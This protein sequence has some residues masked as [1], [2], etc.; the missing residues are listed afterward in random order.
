RKDAFSI[1]CQFTAGEVPTP[2]ATVGQKIRLTVSEPTDAART[3]WPV[4]SGVPFAQGKLASVDDVQMT[5]AQGKVI[6]AQFDVTSRWH[7]G[8]IKWLTCDFA[9]NTQPGDQKAV[10]FLVT[11]KLSKKEADKGAR[12]KLES[13][14]N[15]ILKQS[16][17]TIV[18]ADGVTLQSQMSDPQVETGG[19]VRVSVKA[20]GDYLKTDKTPLFR[21]RCHVTA[22]DSGFVRV[23][24]TI[25]NNKVDEVTTLVHRADWSLTSK[26]SFDKPTLAD[27]TR[28]QKA[29]SVVQDLEKHA[30][31][32]IDG[33]TSTREQLDG[34]FVCG[35]TAIKACD[36]WQTWPK[37]FAFRKGQFRFD[38][39]P[40]L[41]TTDYPPKGWDTPTELFEHFYWYKDGNYMFK[42]GLEI[43][44]E[45]WLVT[46]KKLVQEGKKLDAWLEHPL[47][48]VAPCDYYCESKAFGNINPKRAG[49][50]DT[51]EKAY[52]DSFANLE[53]GR[54][55][56]G[57][58]GWMNFGDWFGE[59][60]WNWGNNEYD[61]SYLMA[62]QF[63][64]SGNTAYVKRGLEMAKHYTTVDFC[65]Y[66]WQEHARE[67]VYAHSTGH[68]GGFIEEGDPRIAGLQHFIA[69][70]RGGQDGSGGHAFHPGNYFMGCL[71]GEK[72]ILEVAQ[73]ACWNQATWYTPA[74]R[75]SIERAAGWALS[76]AVYSYNFTNNPFYLNAAKIYY[77]VI[78]A[79]QNP[80]T[81]CF[82]LRQDQS[83]CDCPDKKEHRGGKA[84][85]V[86]VLLHALARYYETTNDPKV[87]ETI[88]RCADWLLDYSWNES[89]SGFRYKTGCPK[90]ANSGGY[91]IIV[92]EGIAYATEVS[93]NPRYIE[94]LDRTAGPYIVKPVGG[95]TGAGKT[96]S[97]YQ[98]HLPHLLYYLEKHGKT[99]GVK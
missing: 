31:V 80:V 57:E 51:Y 54:Q 13:R 12:A 8:S 21:W 38:I 40:A 86:G 71:T 99:A 96:F 24:W 94:F 84:F 92:S 76:N 55:K 43:C 75:I 30:S 7:D 72:R 56:R 29:L 22:Y 85:A 11:G 10:Y 15:E 62:E 81:G 50:F 35:D 49:K 58:Y 2:P 45:V 88:V 19:P 18:L 9:A 26:Q 44:S 28:A 60:S 23:R 78:V 89:K 53:K 68:V 64:R 67:L 32:T 95:G 69:N 17:S 41:P 70:L 93:G 36:F 77:E 6:P 91:S 1:S 3:N 87:K 42:R 73:I 74:Y 34:F 48:A 25:G 61:L 27:G 37:G 46:D 47:F 39:L 20:E 98:R 66:H 52:E 16:V 14:A 63:A 5:D 90:Y 83:E 97:Q 79:T 33:K 65:A 59:R 82:D 4:T